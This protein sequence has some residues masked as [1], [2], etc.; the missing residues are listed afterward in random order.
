MSKELTQKFEDKKH[1][2]K[3]TDKQHRA[4]IK[5]SFKHYVRVKTA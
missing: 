5:H 1:A 2:N 3:H 4:P